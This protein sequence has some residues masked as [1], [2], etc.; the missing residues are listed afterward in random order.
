MP[1][2]TV[3]VDSC[4]T[5]ESFVICIAVLQC[6]YVLGIIVDS[7][8]WLNVLGPLLWLYIE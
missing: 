1:Y 3:E 6:M 7:G 8:G 5:L 4:T 2:L